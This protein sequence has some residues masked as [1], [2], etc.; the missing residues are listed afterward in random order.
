MVTGFDKNQLNAEKSTTA[1][2]KL[3]VVMYL[4]LNAS[5]HHMRC[6]YDEQSSQITEKWQ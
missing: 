6:S 5:L 4:L 1:L 2:C 3:L